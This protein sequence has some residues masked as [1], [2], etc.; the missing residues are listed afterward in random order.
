MPRRPTQT[1]L[2][3]RT[4]KQLREERVREAMKK[5][6][7]KSKLQADSDEEEDSE[8]E[9]ILYQYGKPVSKKEPEPEEELEEEPEPEPPKPKRK[10]KPK[11]KPVEEADTIKV[12]PPKVQD[13]KPEPPKVDVE[14]LINQR[15]KAVEEAYHKKLADLEDKVKKQHDKTATMTKRAKM[16]YDWYSQ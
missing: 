4:A 16:L 10:P 13:P 8:D 6:V 12:E 2:K 3:K 9:I 7:A 11:P 5:V 1:A 15:L 14:D